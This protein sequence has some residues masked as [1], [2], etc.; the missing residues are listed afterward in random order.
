MSLRCWVLTLPQHV[1]WTD[2]ERELATVADGQSVM[3]YRTA[4]APKDMKSGDR[5]Y[6]V[7][8]GY[9]VGWMNVV[10]VVKRD[11]P[12][13]CSTTGTTWPAGTYIQRSGQFHRVPAGWHMPGFRGVRKLELTEQNAE[14]VEYVKLMVKTSV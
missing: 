3:N 5:C 12:W 8:R 11:E 6:V 7:H 13:I 10:N 14:L 9:V 4:H 2:Y 1:E